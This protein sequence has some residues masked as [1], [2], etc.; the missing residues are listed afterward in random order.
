[1]NDLLI[2][3]IAIVVHE[4][5]HYLSFLSFG[6]NPRIALKWWGISIGEPKDFA[7]MNILK[8]YFL[9]ISGILW[10]AVVLQYFSASQELWLIYIIMS[11]IDINNIVQLFG[12]DKDLRKLTLK[13]VQI[14]QA[15][16][17]IESYQNA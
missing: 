2:L 6:I 1:M 11:G 16:R 13:E 8:Y 5:G 9:N 14:K 4:L 7:N 12:I 10:G 3:L 15:E 17:I